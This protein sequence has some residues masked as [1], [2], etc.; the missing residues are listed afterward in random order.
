MTNKD[1]FFS[2]WSKQVA[3]NA[4]FE[5]RKEQSLLF[6]LSDKNFALFSSAN[7]GCAAS[8]SNNKQPLPIF[9]EKGLAGIAPTNHSQPASFPDNVS[10]QHVIQPKLVA[11]KNSAAIMSG[12]EWGTSSPDLPG[13]VVNKQT[14]EMREAALA[15]GTALNVAD[16]DSL[17]LSGLLPPVVQSLKLQTCLVLKQVRACNTQLERYALLSRVHTENPTLFFHIVSTNINECVPVIY[18]PTVGEACQKFGQ[19]MVP[20][21]GLYI[22]INDKGSVAKVV[23]NWR[24]AAV[25]VVVITDGE[26]I[27]GLGDLGVYGMGIPIGKLQLYTVGGGVEPEACLPLTVDVGTDNAALLKDDYY[28]GLRHRRVRGANYDEF[29]DEVMRSLNARWPGVLIQFE[30]FGNQNA[31]RLLE[32]YRETYCTFNDDIQGTAAVVLAGFFTALRVK[33]N[34]ALVQETVL[35][36]GA[37]EAGTGIADL[38][39]AE[40]VAQGANE[41]DARGKIFLVDS[42]GLVTT[43]RS[44]IASHKRPYA[45]APEGL[46]QKG[47]R[48]GA[49]LREIVAAVAPTA[50]VGVSAQPN[51]FTKEVLEEMARINTRPIV[52]ALSNPTHKAECTAEEAIVHTDG[53]VLFCSGSPFESLMHKGCEFKPS[54]GNNTYIFPGV[55]LGIIASGTTRVSNDLFRV[56][57]RTLSK[58]VSDEDLDKGCLFPPLHDLRSVS[59]SIAVACAKHAWDNNIHRPSRPRPV[60]IDA[61][62]AS[63]MYLPIYSPLRG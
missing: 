50:L 43:S 21:R 31:F 10:L 18:T 49:D 58:M 14:Q 46:Q 62:V 30:D 61:H 34:S 24:Q 17:G 2:W 11:D 3:K 5:Q 7:M 25:K 6:E 9:E 12:G 47:W 28:T 35:I 63:Q 38:L 57:A 1:F 55:G 44:E 13:H 16:R 53:R 4:E 22:T 20:P 8:T 40:M 45:K 51:T 52:F 32:K 42:Q 33:E 48:A 60:D 39:V 23:S 36:Q 41:A 59:H 27:L 37:G 26:R 29:I 54:Q 19:L 15:R 56:A